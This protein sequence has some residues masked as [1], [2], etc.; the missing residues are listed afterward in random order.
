MKTTSEMKEVLAKLA[1]Q[2]PFTGNS[3]AVTVHENLYLAMVLL[4]YIE[5][6]PERAV[7]WTDWVSVG[8][9]RLTPN[10]KQC[11]L[12]QAQRNANVSAQEN[13]SNR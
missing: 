2:E 6:V 11:G 7:S 5:E 3:V 9:H 8:P 13:V 10:G 1:V 12:K 4:G